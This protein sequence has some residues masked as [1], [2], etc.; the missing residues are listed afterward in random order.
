[1]RRMIGR[2][3]RSIATAGKVARVIAVGLVCAT[4]AAFSPRSLL[5]DH[6]LQQWTVEDGLP[7]R[8]VQSVAEGP[9]GYL[10]VATYRHLLRFDGIRFVDAGSPGADFE[11]DAQ[12]TM[13][14]L[15]AAS[16]GT[17][18]VLTTRG[19][20]C[21]GPEGWT[22]PL[23]MPD[24][25]ASRT[26]TLTGDGRSVVYLGGSAGVVT[27]R[28]AKVIEMP[29]DATGWALVGG[30]PQR[31]VGRDL[32][33]HPLPDLG[34]PADPVHLEVHDGVPIVIAG[35]TVVRWNDEAWEVVAECPPL[36]RSAL[37]DR[38]G[39][40]WCGGDQ[41]IRERR[42]DR[43]SVLETGRS[44]VNVAA[45]SLLEDTGGTIWAAT[46]GGLV[47]FR[48]RTQ[49][50]RVVP[51]TGG[52]PGVRAAWIAGDGVIWVTPEQGGVCRLVAGGD[53]FEPVAFPDAP[54][55]LRFETI[56]RGSAGDLW[57]GTDGAGLWHG[58][59]GGPLQQSRFTAEA[60]RMAVIAAFAG[61]PLTRL[62][63]GSGEGLFFLDAGST[64]PR[65]APEPNTNVR[66]VEAIFPDADGTLWIGRQDDWISQVDAAGATLRRLD[67]AGLPRGSVWSFHRDRRGTLWAGGNGLLMRLTEPR[68]VFD[69]THGLPEAAITQIEDSPSGL[70]WLGTRD[71]LFAGDLS[72]IERSPPRRG[73]FRR[74]DA[75]GPLAHAVCTGR[76]NKVQRSTE[77]VFP[78]AQGLVVL[79]PGATVLRRTAPRTLIESLAATR[80][81]GS[82]VAG[83]P[84]GMIVP[85]DATSVVVQFTALHMA[86]PEALRFRYRVSRGLPP[87]SPVV[88]D[89]WTRVGRDRRVV[90][91]G[92][93][94]GRHTFEVRASLDGK[95]AT[96]GAA[97]TLDVEAHFW[98]RPDFVAACGAAAAAVAAVVLV[99]VR[100]RY[101]RRL[102]RERELQQ[103]RERI[104]RDIHDDLGAG[105]TQ[106]AH[107][108]AMAADHD[109]DQGH[110]H[111]AAR[112]LFQ[113][114]CTATTGL[115]RSLDEIVWAVNPANDSLDKLVSYL[116]EFAQEFAAAAGVACRLDLPADVPDRVVSSR[117]RHNVCMLLKESLNNAVMHGMPGEVMVT[118]RVDGGVLRLT[119]LDDGRGFDSGA[120]AAD[121]SGRHSGIPT[122]RHRA[123]EL[124]GRLTIESL[125]GAGTTVHIAV[126]V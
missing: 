11:A 54:A 122:M 61:D 75:E 36:T 72:A 83:T 116:A 20:R 111:D 60:R 76:I 26:T 106:V 15:H 94:A 74:F 19:V 82:I 80:R 120:I 73:L 88:D 77:M 102:S 107:L 85:A 27:F 16:D 30:V 7:E 49:G 2:M 62:W 23:G 105:L 25:A 39:G 87:E 53:A 123:G 112:A 79:D 18:Y 95:Y 69:S 47:R 8:V 51:A 5:D 29:D 84:A 98:Q 81:D 125:P 56:I 86:A 118:M 93:A 97:A 63:I 71:G 24:D 33:P 21:Y 90:I 92:L 10:W 78:S 14:R 40:A 9:D 57:L 121:E 65:P 43:W 22:T 99:V 119:V 3:S 13:L 113:R 35:S 89:E 115:T 12:E 104:A 114:I 64:T 66:V 41:G 103:E 126:E 55:D 17:I 124:G 44:P 38:S 34:H 32:E 59:P 70:L 110:D 101:R 91:R 109:H 100:Q 52:V 96:E 58:A 48:R 37:V 117:V 50:V 67:D 4:A 31:L 28:E 108:S 6:G 45:R 1:M 42:H 68:E 46:D